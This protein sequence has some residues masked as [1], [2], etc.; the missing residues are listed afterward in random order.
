MEKNFTYQQGN[1][2]NPSTLRIHE[3]D[4]KLV[5][6]VRGDGAIHQFV[7][8]NNMG[9]MVKEVINNIVP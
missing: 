4:G 8:S 1:F 6:D 9:Q 5:I 2:G 7:F 3:I